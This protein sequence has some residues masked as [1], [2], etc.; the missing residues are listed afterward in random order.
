MLTWIYTNGCSVIL[1][2]RGM[3]VFEEIS[4]QLKKNLYLGMMRKC[5][6]QNSLHWASGDLKW[7]GKTQTRLNKL[8]RVMAT[9]SLVMPRDIQQFI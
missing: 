1:N 8:W 7:I 3:E 4:V 5:I 6:K 2:I 9:S